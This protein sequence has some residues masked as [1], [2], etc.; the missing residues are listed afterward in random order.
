MK[1][2]GIFQNSAD[3]AARYPVPGFSH[4]PLRKK[5]ARYFSR[6]FPIPCN[7]G[8]PLSGDNGS[9]SWLLHWSLTQ[10]FRWVK[11]PAGS[12][13][14]HQE[15]IPA[16]V[17]PSGNCRCSPRHTEKLSP[18]RLAIHWQPG[19]ASG[20]LLSARHSSTVVPIDLSD[21]FYPSKKYP[22]IADQA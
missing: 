1:H 7:H 16:V 6:Y 4:Q 9:A 2:S 10:I 17:H 8:G 15:H 21:F 13:H 14:W 20:C 18:E 11:R 12:L 5:K 3:K 22:E 19:T